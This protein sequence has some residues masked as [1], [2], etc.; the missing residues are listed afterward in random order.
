M[1]DTA[2]ICSFRGVATLQAPSCT[3]SYELIYLLCEGYLTW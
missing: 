1:D 2:V 3:R